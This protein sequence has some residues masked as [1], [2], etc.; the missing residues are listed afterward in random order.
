MEADEEEQCRFVEET[1]PDKV[2]EV[3][4]KYPNDIVEVWAEDE[5][6][7]GLQPIIRAVWVE[8]GTK[9]A[10]VP[11]KPGYEWFYLYAFVHPQSG[12]SYWWILS[13]LS[14]E[15]FSLALKDF[16]EEFG[17]GKGKQILLVVD[18]AA[19]HMSLK[20]E[21]P[22]GIHL[23]PLPVKSPELQPAERL[24]SYSDETVANQAWDD[25]DAMMDEL[26]KRCQYLMTQEEL[27]SGLTS[28]YWWPEDF[29]LK[30]IH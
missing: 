1:L 9:N 8:K 14:I 24:W 27:I 7:L 26:W 10:T 21:V 2:D 16:A 22:D 30:N 12:R 15:M 13:H 23:V 18:Q 20:L 5:H 3:A 28:Y 19:W 6:R 11:V 17:A 25:I 29:S 4:Q